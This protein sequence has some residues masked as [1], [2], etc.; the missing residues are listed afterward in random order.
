M[1][2]R[3]M[4]RINRSQVFAFRIST[5]DLLQRLS[6]RKIDYYVTHRQLSWLGYVARMTSNRLPRKLLSSWVCNQ[7]LKGAPEFTYGRGVLK[8]LKKANVDANNWY[9]LALN[10]EAWK[11]TLSNILLNS[12]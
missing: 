3:A 1:C 2:L 12:F 6:L 4:C 7:R 9:N 11:V 5:D 10:R 8:A